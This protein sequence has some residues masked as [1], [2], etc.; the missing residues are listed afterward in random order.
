MLYIDSPKKLAAQLHL[1]DDQSE[2]DKELKSA[3]IKEFVPEINHFEKEFL[4]YTIWLIIRKLDS[5]V[6]GSL[7]FH[8][9]P[10][11]GKVEIGYGL[12][13]QFKGFGYMTEAVHQIIEWTKKRTDI[14]SIIAETEK[15]NLQS[16]NVLLRN[17]FKELTRD[18]ESIFWE[19]G[20]K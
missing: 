10:M 14:Q 4:F 18:E 16:Q 8:G 9:E 19:L 15:L 12:N 1:I 7:C 13:V 5:V 11:D 20:V 17:D 3:V 2:A 6:L